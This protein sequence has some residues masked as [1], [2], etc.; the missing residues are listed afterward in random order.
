[1]IQTQETLPPAADRG[2]NRLHVNDCCA[3]LLARHWGFQRI[4]HLRQ[5]PPP[6]IF[7]QQWSNEVHS[8]RPGLVAPCS[9]FHLDDQSSI[10]WP[11]P[12]TSGRRRPPCL[13]AVRALSSPLLQNHR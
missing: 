4:S 12:M 2:R 6:S 13:P 1:M 7:S 10:Q 5:E 11:S 9:S 8:P 3:Q